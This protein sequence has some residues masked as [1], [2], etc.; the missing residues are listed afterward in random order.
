MNISKWKW[1]IC[2]EGK[3]KVTK[4]ELK[5]WSRHICWEEEKSK[6]RIMERIKELDIQDDEER[7][8]ED[9]RKETQ[10]LFVEWYGMCL[11]QEGIDK[12]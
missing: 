11:K 2:Y 9:G 1:N 8:D 6:Q 3:T 12:R 7:L 5:V 10:G 4:G